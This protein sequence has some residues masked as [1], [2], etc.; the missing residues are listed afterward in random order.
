MPIEILAHS[1]DV[2]QDVKTREMS[3]MMSRHRDNTGNKRQLE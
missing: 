1:K 3:R 2:I